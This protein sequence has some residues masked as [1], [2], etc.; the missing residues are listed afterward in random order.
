[1]EGS[2]WQNTGLRRQVLDLLPVTTD[3]SLDLSLSSA[4]KDGVVRNYTRQSS[5]KNLEAQRINHYLRL[6]LVG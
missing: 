5:I 3:V 2:N 1:M 4:K 6:F